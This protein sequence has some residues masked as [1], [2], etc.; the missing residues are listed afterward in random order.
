LGFRKQGDL[1]CAVELA[2][3]VELGSGV[4]MKLS[5]LLILCILTISAVAA[6]AQ[7][8][9]VT[10]FELEKYRQQRVQAE[11]DLRENYEKL[12]FSSPEER[13]K[14]DA[15]Q[16]LASQQLA[17]RLERERIEREEADAAAQRDAANPPQQ[18]YFQSEP[19]YPGY[20]GSLFYSSPGRDRFRGRFQSR[21]PLGYFAGGAFWPAPSSVRQPIFIVRPPVH[22]RH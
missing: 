1:S 8:R 15:E 5:L 13:A 22:R 6:F 12:G 19:V 14:R 16:R 3:V 21:V 10:N 9:T 7:T 11:K 17:E 4:N 2:Q 20:G 18:I